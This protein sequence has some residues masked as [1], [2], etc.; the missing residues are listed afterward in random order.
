MRKLFKKAILS[1]VGVGTAMNGLA[2]QAWASHQD[3]SFPEA[4][5][6]SGI[7]KQVKGAPTTAGESV[8]A[9][10]AATKLLTVFGTPVK[11]AA[12][13]FSHSAEG[14]MLDFT[15]SIASLI[16]RG[17]M[18]AAASQAATA[19]SYE[20]ERPIKVA[21]AIKTAGIASYY[22]P[23]NLKKVLV[24]L[25]DSIL[26]AKRAVI[27]HGSGTIKGSLVTY[28]PFTNKIIGNETSL[29]KYFVSLTKAMKKVGTAQ[30]LDEEVMSQGVEA[31]K[32]LVNVA[33]EKGVPLENI[34]ITATAWA[35]AGADNTPDYIK[36]VKE[37][38]GVPFFILSQA[39]E[40][41]LGQIAVE[42][43]GINGREVVVLD[44]GGA[45][46]QLTYGENVHGLTI[47]SATF[48]E[49]FKN[50]MLSDDLDRTQWTRQTFAR[51]RVEGKRQAR[52]ENT[53]QTGNVLQDLKEVIKNK[54]GGVKGIGA[55][56]GGVLD[57]A[58]VLSP[59]VLPAE[60]TRL[61]QQD[62]KVMME[63]L[64]GLMTEEI[65]DLL[66]KTGTPRHLTGVA[67]LNIPLMYGI[68]K[69]FGVNHIDVVNI[70]SGVGGYFYERLWKKA[71]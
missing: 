63:K 62:L 37:E 30:R 13:M 8:A 57:F 70:S 27:D 56:Y 26:S 41:K 49:N 22:I 25:G 17:I 55:F 36:R 58:K 67:T 45:S 24:E 4:Q 47:G 19:A 11:L 44:T 3:L 64:E 16:R 5:G 53:T 21:L 32:N 51:L 7:S 20:H 61:T 33:L 35:R 31:V 69:A 66:E 9:G 34:V 6:K 48:A 18:D 42:S 1:A 10:V 14:G 60:A 38:T 12:S 28:N 68:M 59:E 15:Q 43:R 2:V 65:G 50:F 40:G 52:G 46:V 54:G 29:G 39:E 71:T 23:S